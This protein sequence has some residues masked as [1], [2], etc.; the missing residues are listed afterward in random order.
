MIFVALNNKNQGFSLINNSVI[1]IY[2]LFQ[3][4]LANCKE[5]AGITMARH[6]SYSHHSTKFTTVARYTQ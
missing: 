2:L 1:L 4:V 6:D 3:L 5:Y